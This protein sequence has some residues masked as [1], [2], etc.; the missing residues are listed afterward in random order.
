MLNRRSATWVAAVTM[1]PEAG[2]T[3]AG[4]AGLGT[5]SGAQGSKALGGGVKVVVLQR[6]WF[7][8]NPLL[9]ALT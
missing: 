6:S 1:S 2:R 5:G 3:V 4:A 9:L 7:P 8:K